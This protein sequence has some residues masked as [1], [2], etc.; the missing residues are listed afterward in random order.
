M[1]NTLVICSCGS[2][3]IRRDWRSKL[4][5]NETLLTCPAC[6]WP[7]MRSEKNPGMT[8]SVAGDIIGVGGG[9]TGNSI[10]IETEIK[11]E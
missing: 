4:Q 3:R 2:L 6:L 11:L 1:R 5:K 10:D 9:G 8:I 7:V